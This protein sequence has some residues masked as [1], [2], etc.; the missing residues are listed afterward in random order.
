MA[1][2][3]SNA[4]GSTNQNTLGTVTTGTWNAT[5]VTVPYGGSG[6]TSFTAYSILAAGTTATGTFQNVVGVGTSGQVLT[7]AGAGALP[8]WSSAAT[9][10]VTSVS[11]TAS[12]ITST[13]GA[14]PVIDISGSYVGQSS[15]TT[16][17]TITT[18]VWDGTD[19]AVT[20]GGTGLSTMTTAYA[21]V[22]AGTTAT[23]AL[24]VAS[25]GLATAGFVLT[26]TG[27]ASLPTWQAVG[28]GTVTSVT[29][30]TDRITVATGTTTPVID[31]AATYVGQTSLTT[32]GTVA[33]GTW[34]A[35]NI[36][37]NKGGTN[38]SLTANNGG[39][40]YSTATA[41]AILSGT[42]TAGQMLRSGA[43]AAPT[44]STATFPATATGTGTILRADGTNWLASTATY[45]DSTTVNR[46]LY[47][48]ATN[49]VDQIATGNNGTLV[50]S[51][52]GVPSISSTLPSAVMSNITTLG[53]VTTGVWNGTA[54]TVPYGGTE[55]TSFTAYAPVIGGTTSTSALQSAATGMTT[56]GYVLTSTGSSSA[57]T[58]QAT[59]S[60]GSGS[61]KYWIKITTSGGVPSIAGSFN[62]TSITD[63]A[64]G[65][66]TVTIGTDFSS[67]NWAALSTLGTSGLVQILSQAAGTV[68]LYATTNAGSDFDPAAYYSSGF[69]DQ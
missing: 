7:S 44:W 54:V 42:A 14:T 51:A 65:K 6:N 31:I 34:S 52:G 64:V 61:A 28:A 39:I 21:P 48:S 47:S 38:A 50:T 13:G 30:T 36:A 26:S 27:A 2:N 57:P 3:S 53:T 41:G 23:G 8:T 15:I 69:G 22:C 63:N 45:P 29:G 59:S 62:V 46:I 43:T 12:R 1:I 19:V 56:S 9:G 58:W 68:Q 16:L 17:G 66:V 33:T 20:A 40:F 32:L 25:T 18:G 67:T 35:T 10:T 24:Q 55:A 4:T 11:G 49:V 60:S 5:P 37:L